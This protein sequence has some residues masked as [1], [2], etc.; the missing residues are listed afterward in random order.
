MLKRSSITNFFKDWI[1]PI[2]IALFLC[3]L[4][5][6]FLLFSAEIDSGSM[7]PTLNVGDRVLV[8]K[9]YNVDNIK[10]GDIIVFSKE[11]ERLP[12]IKRVIGLPGDEVSIKNGVVYVNGEEIK[13]DYVKNPQNY[14]GDFKVPDGHFFF[15]GDNRSNSK[16]SREW[17]DPYIYKEKIIGKA[18][19]KIYPI[20][21]FGNL[22]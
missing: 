8:T 10:H 2:I 9:I 14:T 12:L 21:D 7:I 11:G 4:I 16:D 6:R 19:I 20:K 15:L 18:R 13:E 1:L 3:F 22:K 5:T 17:S